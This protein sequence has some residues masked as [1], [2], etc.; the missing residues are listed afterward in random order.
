MKQLQI[1]LVVFIFSS[2]AQSQSIKDCATCLSKNIKEEQIADLS[3]DELRF[4]SNDLYARKGYKFKSNDIDSYYSNKTWYKALDNN[5][6]IVY[7]AIE[8]QNIEMFQ[9]RTVVLKAERDKLISELKSFKTAIL[10][11]DK[12][13]LKN[14][15]SFS[16]QNHQYKNITEALTKINLDDVN[17][18]KNKAL[19]SVIVDNGDYVMAYELKIEKGRV[20]VQYASRGGSEIGDNMYPRESDEY[21]YWWEFEWKNDTLEFIKMSAAG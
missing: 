11:N 6:K 12:T 16:T 18:L 19:Y 8:K 5:N 3:I 21:S 20:I 9:Q 13:A 1:L 10:A 2:T 17:W 14:K 15:Y 7:S 4:L